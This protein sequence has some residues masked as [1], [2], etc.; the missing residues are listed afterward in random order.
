[1]NFRL[2]PTHSVILMSQ[3]SNAPY[4]DRVHEDGVTIEYEGHD[5]PKHSFEH[6]PKT[7]DQSEKL[8]NCKLTQNGLF[9][10][11]IAKY[12]NGGS[13]PELVK[14]YEKILPGVWSLKGY[15]DLIEYKVVYDGKRNVFRFILR[16]SDRNDIAN[17]ATETASQEHTRLIP[18]EIKKE[19]WK[20]DK[21]HLW[22][23]EKSAL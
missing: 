7:E 8:P 1:M 6:N 16:L 15:F 23:H 11:A 17:S 21:G 14:A 12:K 13:A 19:V 22:L 2:K 18:S 10:R 4:R 20:R 9:I 3:R 5:V